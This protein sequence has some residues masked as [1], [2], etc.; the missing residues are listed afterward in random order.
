M[1]NSLEENNNKKLPTVLVI[2][3][4][5]N[6]NTGGGIT[7]SNLFHNYDT[8]K[9]YSIISD[10][11]TPTYD[12][13]KNYYYLNYKE[14]TPKLLWK[15]VNSKIG[16][17]N[18]NSLGSEMKSKNRK[19]IKRIWRNLLF[20]IL[21]YFGINHFFHKYTISD[22]LKNWLSQ[23]NKIDI[24]Y[25]Q[26]ADYASMDFIKLIVSYL[27]KP[28]IIHVMDDWIMSGAITNVKTAYYENYLS[29]T[30]WKYFYNKSFKEILKLADERIC[31]SESM[32]LEYRKRYK[33][34]FSWI[35]N[36]VKLSDWSDN[37]KHETHD[38]KKIISY[39]G[40]I[41]IKNFECFENLCKAIL[42]QKDFE[43][44]LNIYTNDLNLI[45]PLK[46]K[47]KFIETRNFLNFTDYKTAVYK[48]SILFLPLGF[49][50]KAIKYT[51]FSFP[52]KLP[53]YLI[54]GVPILLYAPQETAVS[55]FC[56]KTQSAKCVTKN[57]L[58]DL[59]IAIIELLKDNS[60]KSIISQNAIK[61]CEKRYTKEIIQN[62]FNNILLKANNRN[63]R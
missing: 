61:T 17:Q 57:S 10:T 53:E 55:E 24:I 37:S 22:E 46:N 33:F 48:S 27:Q 42:N 5:F 28:L 35:H 12:V 62:R 15:F 18:N 6:R 40:T 26:Y 39:F 21:T 45:D 20:K 2:G 14:R 58:S 32:S 4:A 50:K 36:Y 54:S 60:T 7:I 47:F 23:I 63:E 31:I 56:L 25:G 19:Q 38:E 9:L 41:D 34:E 59:T 16:K 1:S 43:I 52:T 51:K 8:N 29:R 11:E 3:Q 49:S 30:I 13:C 44:K